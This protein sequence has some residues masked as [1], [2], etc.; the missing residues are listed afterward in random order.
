MADLLKD[1]G[2][3][4]SH[5]DL[6]RHLEAITDS[7]ESMKEEADNSGGTVARP[8]NELMAQVLSH[9][10]TLAGVLSY[11]VDRLPTEDGV[12]VYIDEHGNPQWVPP[13]PPKVGI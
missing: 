6:K 12:N 11:V 4:A 1:D 3:P 7:I 13:N 2:S 8:A 9:Q 5:E 10:H